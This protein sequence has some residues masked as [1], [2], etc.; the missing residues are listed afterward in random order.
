MTISSRFILVRSAVVFSN[1][2]LA[3]LGIVLAALSGCAAGPPGRPGSELFN[4][5]DTYCF[6]ADWANCHSCVN[7]Q[8]HCD[9]R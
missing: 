4:C 3:V 7:R 1:L 6:C 2:R 5:L 9:C 8:C